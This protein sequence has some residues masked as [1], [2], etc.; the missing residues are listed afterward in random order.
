MVSVFSLRCDARLSP[1]N[2][3]WGERIEESVVD[4]RERRCQQC[5]VSP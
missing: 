3:G 1:D 5:W 4:Y 2:P